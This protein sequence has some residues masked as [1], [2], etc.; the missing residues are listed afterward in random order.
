[1][2]LLFLCLAPGPARASPRNQHGRWKVRHR[3]V[4][5]SGTG[6]RAPYPAR[7]IESRPRRADYMTK[8]TYLRPDEVSEMLRIWLMAML[9]AALIVVVHDHDVLRR[10]GLIGYCT[11]SPRPAGTTGEWRACEKGVLDGRPNLSRQSCRLRAQ[12]GSVEY[13]SC[14]ARVESG[15]VASR[16]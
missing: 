2:R 11:S 7:V 4:P 15:P 16:R 10:A 5:V 8:A 9:A 12:N 14:P 3:V 13:W 1:V 6:F